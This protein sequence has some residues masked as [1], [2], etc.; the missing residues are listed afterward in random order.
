MAARGQYKKSE[1][2]RQQV[3]DA[4]IRALAQGGFA[5]TTVNDIARAAGMSKGAVHYHFARKADLI[6]HVL[7]RCLEVTHGR[8]R[9]AWDA[10]GSPTDKIRRGLREMRERWRDGGPELRVVADL[11]AQ[12]VH[13][14]S[15]RQPVADMFQK[16]RAEIIEHLIASLAAMGLKP[17]IPAHIIPRL[18]LA[19]LDGLALHDF[20][21]PPGPDDHEQIL[22]AIEVIAFSLFEL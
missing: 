15:L 10:P 8:L 1:A 7:E 9:A 2:S 5:R 4:A 14:A 17:K 3:V 11:M 13:D 16:A 12:G 18:L 22:R 21:D 6:S 20:F 19:T